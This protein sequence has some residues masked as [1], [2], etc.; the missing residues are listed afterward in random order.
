MRVD[1]FEY[2]L[3]ADLIAQQPLPERD[4]ARL[5]V[6]QAGAA[7]VAHRKVSDLPDLLDRGS[8]L[9]VN[10][11]RVVPARIFGRKRT[12]G[13][14]EWLLVERRGPGE[15]RESS[16]ELRAGEVWRALGKGLGPGE[17]GTTF[18]VLA[19]DS[20]DEEAAPLR[21]TLLGRLN[22]DGLREVLLW[23]PAGSPVRDSLEACGHV[24][25]PPYI[26]RSD[27]TEDFSRYQTVYARV[28]GAI[29]APTAGLHLTHPILGR[30]AA[31]GCEV[32]SLTLHV[33]L[34]T[35]KPVQALDLD[36]HAMHAE[37]FDVPER[38]VAAVARARARGAPVVAVGTTS[39]R[40]LESAADPERLGHVR[41]TSGETRILI[42]PGHPWR[43]VDALLTNFHQP[44]STLMALVCAFAGTERV[45]AAY[46]AAVRERYRF[47]SYGDAMLLRRDR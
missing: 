43:V 33:G 47:F 25:L 2:E 11:T 41:A 36:Q 26:K 40:A 23:T 24:P 32:A 30:L 38:T 6:L 39:V 18:E 29:A 19:R 16:G 8:V 28:D 45:L 27:V 15:I 12:G 37:A 14:V 17:P 4:L 46:R 22:D 10:D 20:S 9:V 31:K 7:A 44:R 3:P 5:M 1:A 34:G 42:Q 13:R 21:L 35:F